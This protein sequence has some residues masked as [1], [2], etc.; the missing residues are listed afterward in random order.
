MEPPSTH[1]LSFIYTIAD[2]H[3]GREGAFD[4]AD[5][6]NYFGLQCAAG[7]EFTSVV[8]EIMSNALLF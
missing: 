1:F 5:V 8:T 6:D 3:Q 2:N 7:Q 4:N